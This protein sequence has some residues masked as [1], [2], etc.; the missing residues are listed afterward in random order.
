MTKSALDRLTHTHV[1]PVIIQFHLAVTSALCPKTNPGN[2]WNQESG[3]T[4]IHL[5]MSDRDAH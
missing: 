1:N 5:V 4:V 2:K 3:K